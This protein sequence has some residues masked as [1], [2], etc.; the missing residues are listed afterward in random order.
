MKGYRLPASAL[1]ELCED[2]DTR[3]GNMQVHNLKRVHVILKK[4]A[5]HGQLMT[6][7]EPSR[8][9]HSRFMKNAPSHSRDA[10][11]TGR[12]RSHTSLGDNATE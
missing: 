11:L 3:M 12:Q 5:P 9:K 1:Y 10:T 2:I 4:C 6:R 8:A 7:S